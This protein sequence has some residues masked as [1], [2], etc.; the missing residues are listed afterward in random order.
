MMQHNINHHLLPPLSMLEVFLPITPVTM[1]YVL[2]FVFPLRP[3]FTGR[4]N[5]KS[6]R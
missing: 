3:A 1:R 2:T 5:G 6:V 4:L